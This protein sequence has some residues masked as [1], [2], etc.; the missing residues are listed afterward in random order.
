MDAASRALFIVFVGAM[1]IAG[2]GLNFALNLN[3]VPSIWNG[4]I[5]E[6]LLFG[7]VGVA[8]VVY[9]YRVYDRARNPRT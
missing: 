2:A 5:Y 9:G 1:F 8:L 4:F 3:M 7:A 6:I